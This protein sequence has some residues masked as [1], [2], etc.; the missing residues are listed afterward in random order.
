MW[1][2]NLVFMHL[3]M[4]NSSKT[5]STD[6]K[7][8]DTVTQDEIKPSDSVSNVE[9]ES[10]ARSKCRGH[11]RC[12]CKTSIHSTTSSA[13]IKVKA[14]M[15]ALIARQRLLKEKHHLEHQEVQPCKRKL[16]LELQFKIEVSITK[17]NVLRD[18]HNPSNI[19]SI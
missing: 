11:P 7:M 19:I 14:D 4:T 3:E 15:V 10:S 18:F 6:I 9:V 17:V 16:Q 13:H 8:P 1:L 12:S 5:K 2:Q